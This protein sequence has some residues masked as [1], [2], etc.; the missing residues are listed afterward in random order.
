MPNNIIRQPINPIPS[1]LGHFRKPFSFC[2]VFERVSGEVYTAAVDVCFDENVDAA[3]AVEWDFD[4]FVFAPVSHF[5]HVGAAGV[6]FFVAFEGK[7][8]SGWK[9]EREG[10]VLPSARTVSLSRE[11]ASLRPFSDS[12]HEL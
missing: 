5:C 10:E 3:D 7:G 2:L 11:A 12:C 6:V 4:V 8:V 1:P 9:G